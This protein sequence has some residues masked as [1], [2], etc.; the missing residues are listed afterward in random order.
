MKILIGIIIPLILSFSWQQEVDYKINIELDT[1]QHKI[2][3]SE[4]LKYFNNSPDTLPELWLHLYPNAYRDRNSVWAKEEEKMKNFSFSLARVKDRGYISIES[5]LVDTAALGY[6]INDTKMRVLLN[7]PLQPGD[8]TI[9][10]INFIIKIP[11]IF[12]RLG[13]KDTH[14]EIVQWYPKICVYDKT[15]WHNDNYHAVGEFYGEFGNYDV[16]IT[17]PVEFVV[18][19]TG[20]MVEP[21]AEIR[22]LDSFAISGAKL[23]SLK[24][25]GKIKCTY[26]KG[27]YNKTVRYLATDVHD[28][29]WVAD[30]KYVLI[31]KTYDSTTIN[32]LCFEKDREWRL[33]ADYAYDALKYYSR[34]YGKYPYK[35]LTVARGYFGGGMEYPNLVIIG[36]SG[37][38]IIRSLE[39]IIMHEIG[40]QWFYGLLATNETDEAWLDEGINTFSEI[41]YLEAKYGPEGNILKTKLLPPLGQRKYHQ[42]VYYVTATN[43]L[44]KPILTKSFEFTDEPMPVAY[45][46]AAYSKPGLMMYMLKNH[47]GDET[48]DRIMQRYF[49]EYKFHHPA[50][51]DF[52][53]IA[54]SASDQDLSFFF[55]PWLRTIDYCDYAIKKVH[56]L[57]TNT[58]VIVERKG[59]IIMPVEVLIETKNGPQYLQVITGDSIMTTVVFS[60]PGSKVKRVA[61]DP[62]GK[63]LEIDRWNNYYPR[64]IEIKPIFDF[65]S[66]EAYQIF[67]GPWASY[68]QKAGITLSSWF[69][70]RR[71]VDYDFLL[72][73]HQ[74]HF[75]L[76]YRP[77]IRDF[78]FS[79][80]YQTPLCFSKNIKTRF[81]A[82]IVDG[83]WEFNTGGQ[84]KTKIAP[85]AFYPDFHE[86]YTGVEFL[87]IKNLDYVDN[88]DFEL[89]NNTTAKLGHKY[90]FKQRV[91]RGE[92]DFYIQSGKRFAAGEYNFEKIAGLI[93]SNFTINRFFKIDWRFFAGFIQGNAPIQ[94]EFFLSGSNRLAGINSLLFDHLGTFSPQEHLHIDGGGNLVGYYG[95]HI[96]CARIIALNLN[97][98]LFKFPITP[99][100]N[101]G[102]IDVATVPDTSGLYMD[103]GIKAK[104][105]PIVGYFPIWI[106]RP[107]PGENNLKLRW[108]LELFL[109]LSF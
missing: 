27:G 97:P 107:E 59:N 91:I 62:D 73:R 5:L 70:G 101:A 35:N 45:A 49:E 29:A 24:K 31:Q 36:T 77:K 80:N 43:G 72:G 82:D 99:L 52:I 102:Y 39:F 15:G 25:R 41:R 9:L 22:Y 4:L 10:K 11:K 30:K 98:S 89:G 65:P 104:V 6:E 109:G 21:L 92:T 51:A 78:G 100:F 2:Y 68:N 19:A 95:R 17:L 54:E 57:K 50:T 58:H 46:S 34:W 48:F 42:F 90:K 67:F 13:H 87:K 32:I 74:W 56:R 8:S 26:R 83:L 79:V 84:I 85:S 76:D 103:A 88:R 75:S 86:F 40:H 44:E 18:G 60:A 81:N 106:N 23:D 69:Q 33:A 16:S 12:S 93:I 96:H 105:G 37:S 66:F 63:L 14:Y 55:A 61:I 108:L 20:E 38:P 28:F 7:R 3:G 64:K 94:D 47:V 1:A 71:F 53:K